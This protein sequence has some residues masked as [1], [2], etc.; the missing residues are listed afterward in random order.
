AAP[1]RA[2]VIVRDVAST[3][4]GL[5]DE[6]ARALGGVD[7]WVHA[8]GVAAHAPLEAISDEALAR[9]H[10]LHVRAPLR[11]AQE[12][13]A[14]L[15]AAGGPGAMV[16]IAST[17]ALRPAAGTIVYAATK[18]AQLA[19]AKGLALELAPDAIRVNAIAPGVV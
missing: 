3:P 7:G 1:E 8:A 2:A 13:A 16:L 12:L 17:L 11:I 9:A 4:E 6:A 5:V 19:L 10:A 15:R 18:A 14:H